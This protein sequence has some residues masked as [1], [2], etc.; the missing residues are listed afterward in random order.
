[1]KP[2]RESPVAVLGVMKEKINN[3]TLTELI[4][5]I[6]IIALL[7][8]LLFPAIPYCPAPG[9]EVKARAC[10]SAIAIAIKQYEN[11]YGLLPFGEE[12]TEKDTVVNSQYEVLMELLSCV[13]SPD[14]GDN[15]TKNVRGI[16]FLVVPSNFEEEG[17]LDPWGQQIK[18]FIDTN[19]DGKIILDGKE[20]KGNVLIYSYGKNKIDNKGKDDDI[21][22][23]K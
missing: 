10:L 5:I 21:C 9:P 19:Y 8:A 11:T 2:L 14:K 15:V 16:M 17:Y 1:V 7:V 12:K 3:L 4:V 13:D 22:S 20:I 18:V 6:A 23:W